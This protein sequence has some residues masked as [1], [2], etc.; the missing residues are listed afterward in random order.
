MRRIDPRA[1]SEIGKQSLRGLKNRGG[2]IGDMAEG[3]R[4]RGRRCGGCRDHRHGKNLGERRGTNRRRSLSTGPAR[5]RPGQRSDKR[6]EGKSVAV[7]VDIGGCRSIKQKK[8][9]VK[10]KRTK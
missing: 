9:K 8:K 5:P 6:R 10:W 4:R 2:R 1:V 3:M 7:R